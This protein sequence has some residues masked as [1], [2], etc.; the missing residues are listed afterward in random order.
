MVLTT[1]AAVQA[2]PIADWTIAAIAYFARG[3]DRMREFQAAE[4]WARQA[5]ADLEVRV[6]ELGELRL[7]V[8]G[9]G[10]IGA[11]IAR[12][13]VALGM[14]VAGLR[15]RPAPRGHPGVRWGGGVGDLPRLGAER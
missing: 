12:R 14:S 8:L 13:G 3:L 1:S 15:R 9:L 10:G 2:E 11:A 4:R 5:F 7:G 6:R